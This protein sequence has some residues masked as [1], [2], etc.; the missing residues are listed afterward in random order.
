VGDPFG[1]GDPIIAESSGRTARWLTAAAVLVVLGVGAGA[2]ALLWPDDDDGTATGEPSIVVGGETTGGPDTGGPDTDGPGPGSRPTD[3]G[4][5]APPST[6][7]ADLIDGNA[8]P[9]VRGLSEAIGAP[10]RARSLVLYDGYAIL[11]FQDPG[12]PQ[13][14]DRY[15]WRPDRTDGPDPVALPQGFTPEVDASL[16]GLTDVRFGRLPS[17]ARAAAGEFDLD[18]PEVTHVIIDRFNPGL[19]DADVVI[20]VYVRDPDRG[21]G[22]YARFTPGGRLL[23][24]VG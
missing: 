1:S 16:F 19:G 7:P 11:E 20:R 6:V 23:G 17:M 24:V 21:G 15:V 2:V 3:P 18:D 13:H 14:I 4:S 12:N 8:R 9:A 10:F 22:G 5:E